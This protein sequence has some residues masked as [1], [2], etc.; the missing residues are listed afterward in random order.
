LA[1]ARCCDVLYC[2]G[3]IGAG[4]SRRDCDADSCWMNYSQSIECGRYVN[5]VRIARDIA[6]KQRYEAED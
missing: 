6:G 2:A 3:G 5:R 1:V 4:S